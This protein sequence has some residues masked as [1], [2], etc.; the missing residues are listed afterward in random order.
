M[1]IFSGNIHTKTT[2]QEKQKLAY[3]YIVKIEMM[4]SCK[5][6]CNNWFGQSSSI[7]A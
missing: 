2:R 4:I 6:E 7:S 1:S 3:N 5:P